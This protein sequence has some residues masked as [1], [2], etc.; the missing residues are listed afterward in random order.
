MNALI[1]LA[2]GKMTTIPK[3]FGD[4]NMFVTAAV[5]AV[6]FLL[7]A[8]L[9]SS[10]IKYEP[11]SN[12]K[13]PRKRRLWFW[14]LGVLAVILVFVLLFFVIPVPVDAIDWTNFTPGEQKKYAD[15]MAHYMMMAGIATGT[16]FVVYV[17]LGLI[18]SKVFKNKKIG[19]WF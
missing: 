17:V 18:L 9:I 7:L 19:D 16:C 11:G 8:I 6:G 12:P 5:C 10:L 1:L 4:V 2:A 3:V 14:I 13:D 15:A